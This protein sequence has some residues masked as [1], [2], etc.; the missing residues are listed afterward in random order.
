MSDRDAVITAA[1]SGDA[2]TLRRLLATDRTLASARDDLGIS[3][4]L[5]ARYNGHSDA[6]SA[7]LAANPATDI[8]DASA[9]GLLARVTELVAANPELAN[10]ANVDGFRPLQLG[11]FFGNAQVVRVLLDAGADVAGRSTNGMSLQAIHSAA[12]AG[13][14]GIVGM[15][16][17][18]GADVNSEQVGG[19]TAL[20]AADQ[21]GDTELQTLLL[22]AG[23][24]R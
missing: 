7:L 22:A 15:L 16:L 19:Y 4:L 18:A 14:T 24:E 23:A 5:H 12:A 10:A 17:E 6:V 2:E 20:D 1:E 9:V 8:F 3:A 21:N 11:S 13:H